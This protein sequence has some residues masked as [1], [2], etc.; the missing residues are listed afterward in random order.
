MCVCLIELVFLYFY[1][2]HG[3]RILRV[4]TASQALV[5]GCNT[6]SRHPTCPTSMVAGNKYLFLNVT[7]IIVV[8]YYTEF[9]CQ[10][11][12]RVE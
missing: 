6:W 11:L 12:T 10:L 5:L 1:Q 4:A 2:N 3:K 8:F 9:L 7:V